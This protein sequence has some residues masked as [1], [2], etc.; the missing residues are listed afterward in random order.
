[1]TQRDEIVYWA[2]NEAEAVVILARLAEAGIPAVKVQESYGAR[3]SLSFGILGQIG[4]SVK[5]ELADAAEA[6]ILDWDEDWLDEEDGEE[7]R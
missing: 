6:V 2:E 5:A 7:E 1:M 3:N 4:I